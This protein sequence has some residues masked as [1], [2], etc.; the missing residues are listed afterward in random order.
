MASGECSDWGVWNLRY[1]QIPSRQRN[2]NGKLELESSLAIRSRSS[3]LPRDASTFAD[4]H[5]SAIHL[6]SL[7]AFR[8]CSL[9]YAVPNAIPTVSTHTYVQVRTQGETLMSKI[10]A[11]QEGYAQYHGL[12]KASRN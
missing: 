1:T 11:R 2:E 7:S 3:P 9:S 12:R 4:L 10:I 5:F 8:C 6:G